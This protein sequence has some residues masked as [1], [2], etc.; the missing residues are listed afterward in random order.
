M[1]EKEKSRL[2]I[3]Y[4]I[5][6]TELTDGKFRK[7]GIKEGFIIT[8]VNNSPVR[9]VEDLKQVIEST[10]GGVYI[11]GVY[12]NGIVAYYAFGI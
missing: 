7:A 10:D 6:V 1:S 9:S 5:K 2:R 12:P 11:E 4:G 3:R 8:Q